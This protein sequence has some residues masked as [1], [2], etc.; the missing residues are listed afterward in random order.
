[1]SSQSLITVNEV[2]QPA[3]INVIR[4]REFHNLPDNRWEEGQLQLAVQQ[5]LQYFCLGLL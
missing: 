3:D 1:V 4:R 2:G 5:T